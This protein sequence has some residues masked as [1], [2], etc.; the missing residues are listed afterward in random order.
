MARL[1]Y[2]ATPLQRCNLSPANLLQGH[3]NKNTDV[4][5]PKS[6]FIPQWTHAWQLKELHSAWP[7]ALG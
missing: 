3:K 5:Q 7:I 4:S 1:N 6:A 2:C